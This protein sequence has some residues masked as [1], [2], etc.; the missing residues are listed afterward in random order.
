MRPNLDVLIGEGVGAGASIDVEVGDVLDE[1]V[2][3]SSPRA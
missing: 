1:S 3:M 2:S